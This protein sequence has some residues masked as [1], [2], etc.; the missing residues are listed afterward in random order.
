LRKAA[1]RC[2]IVLD[3]SF[4]WRHRFL[5][6]PKQKKATAVELSPIL[7]DGLVDQAAAV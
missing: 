4:R 2:G 5:Q 7:G 1:K 3:T 6:L